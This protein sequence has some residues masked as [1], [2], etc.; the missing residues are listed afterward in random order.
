VNAVKL[1]VAGTVAVMATLT[2]SPTRIVEDSIS[3]TDVDEPRRSATDG[4]PL[5]FIPACAD[6]IIRRSVANNTAEERPR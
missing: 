1:A 4:S 5:V 2:I 6:D 3:I